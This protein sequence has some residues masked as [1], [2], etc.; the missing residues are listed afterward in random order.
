MEQL[1]KAVAK[2]EDVLRQE[3]TE[4]MRDSAIQRFEFTFELAWKT[5]KA[6]LESKGVIVYSPRD[7]I[8]GAFQDG[9][10]DEDRRWLEMIETRN[11]TSHVYNEEIAEKIYGRLPSYVPLINA[12][13]QK[14]DKGS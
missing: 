10:I 3:K 14:I 13:L 2:L 8:R 12:F 11:L 4:Y 7:A 6:H 1:R 9:R 5:M